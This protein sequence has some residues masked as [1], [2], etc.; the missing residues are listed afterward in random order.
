MHCWLGFGGGS[1]APWW[2]LGERICE[3]VCE[4]M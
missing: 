4:Q 2:R 3:G 1:E